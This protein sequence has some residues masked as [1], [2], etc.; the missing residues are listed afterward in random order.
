MDSH[1]SA[2][3]LDLVLHL[4]RLGATG[5]AFGWAAR[6]G[7]TGA[8]VVLS[9]GWF[10]EVFALNHDTVHGAFG[11]PR[12]WHEAAVALGG[13]VMLQ[14]GHGARRMHLRHHARPLAADDI[15]GAAVKG[16]FVR[17]LA[18]TPW[19]A[20]RYRVAAWQGAGRRGQAW[21][22]AEHGLTVALAAGMLASGVHGLRVY[23]AVTAVLQVAMPL[24]AGRVPHHAP[25]W[26][27]RAAA[28][29]GWTRSPTALSLAYHALHHDHPA[30]PCQRLG[31]LAARIPV[32]HGPPATARKA[33]SSV[34]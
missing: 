13:L 26:V 32:T 3:R 24:W 23:V 12:R 30:V 6:V 15:E 7:S 4:V 18:V 33:L 19:L 34:A 2:G 14:S 22:L 21:Q 1:R 9:V 29:L 25:A 27:A 8:L 28:C 10:L 20:L 31:E 11:L 17:A 16:S 5:L